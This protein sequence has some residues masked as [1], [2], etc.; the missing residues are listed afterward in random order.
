MW[1]W[2]KLKNI[3][4]PV[5]PELSICSY[6]QNHGWS[7]LRPGPSE[8]LRGLTGFKESTRKKLKAILRVQQQIKQLQSSASVPVREAIFRLPQLPKFTLVGLKTGACAIGEVPWHTFLAS[9]TEV[10]T[11]GATYA[12]FEASLMAIWVTEGA[13]RLLP[14]PAPKRCFE[15]S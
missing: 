3:R 10:I 5:E 6:L 1:K 4:K 15:H 13:G 12:S 2:K 8:R 11:L 7:P 14:V 9:L